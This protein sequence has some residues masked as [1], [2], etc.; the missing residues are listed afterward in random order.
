MTVRDV[1]A[2][3]NRHATGDERI[4]LAAAFRAMQDALL[5]DMAQARREQR[6]QAAEALAVAADTADEVRRYFGG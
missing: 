1:L 4:A 3:V 6:Y 2:G 5:K